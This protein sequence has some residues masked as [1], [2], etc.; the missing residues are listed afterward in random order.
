MQ[1]ISKM[2]SAKTIS[3]KTIRK[4]FAQKR[5]NEMSPFVFEQNVSSSLFK[6]IRMEAIIARNGAKTK[7]A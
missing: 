6:Y 4:V 5:D 1:A 7:T 2:K 3:P